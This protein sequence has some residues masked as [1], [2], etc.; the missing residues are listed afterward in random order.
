M[1]GESDTLL[2]FLG[3]LRASVDRKLVDL[4]EDDARRA[5]VPSGT[6]LLGS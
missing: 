6:T 3:Y 2:A 4:S 5:L 1:S